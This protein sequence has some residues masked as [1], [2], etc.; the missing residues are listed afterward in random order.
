VRDLFRA[1]N[2]GAANR[3]C[4][5][6][7]RG[8]TLDGDRDDL[9]TLLGAI[10]APFARGRS[11]YLVSALSLII[12]FEISGD[13][14]LLFPSNSSGQHDVDQFH[15]MFGFQIKPK[16]ERVLCLQAALGAE[17]RSALRVTPRHGPLPGLS[18][19][20]TEVAF[21]EPKLTEVP[22]KSAFRH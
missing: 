15:L 19:W 14:A 9:E 6:C 8:Q 7:C 13:V 17:K 12:T 11:K 18:I 21:L 5:R 1:G 16:D 4:S 20:L 2:T 3:W 22:V 10:D